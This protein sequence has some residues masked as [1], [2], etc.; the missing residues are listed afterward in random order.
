VVG[1]GFTKIL[2][3]ELLLKLNIPLQKALTA[4]S[5]FEKEILI[6]ETSFTPL[7]TE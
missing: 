2:N 5:Y 6:R 7:Q 4:L 3:I 1:I